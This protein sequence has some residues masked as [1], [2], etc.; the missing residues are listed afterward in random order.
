[1]NYSWT[2]EDRVINSNNYEIR[3]SKYRLLSPIDCRRIHQAERISRRL[4][5]HNVIIAAGNE[6][7]GCAFGYESKH[8]ACL[9]AADM[10]LGY[11]K[12]RGLPVPDHGVIAVLSFA[13]ILGDAWTLAGS[14]V[15]TIFTRERLPSS[16][17]LDE[18]FYGRWTGPHIAANPELE[19]NRHAE[20]TVNLAERRILVQPKWKAKPWE[21]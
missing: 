3:D 12:L 17:Q 16:D 6:I 19:T 1:M 21:K 18:Y 8:D 15:D 7:V 14:G 10:F 13:P 5:G 2:R 20:P 4:P 9:A 11:Y